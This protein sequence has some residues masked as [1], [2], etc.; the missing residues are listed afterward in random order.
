MPPR[1]TAFKSANCRQCFTRWIHRHPDAAQRLLVWYKNVNRAAM[2]IL[3]VTATTVFHLQKQGM[4]TLRAWWA[5]LQAEQGARGESWNIF[6]EDALASSVTGLSVVR[7]ICWKK[8][9]SAGGGG[10]PET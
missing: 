3:S 4:M 10:D 2:Q 8:P 5:Q 7:W 1:R 9:A 6:R